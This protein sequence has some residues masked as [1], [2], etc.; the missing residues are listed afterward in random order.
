LQHRSRTTRLRLICGI[1]AGPLYLVVSYAEAFTRPGFDLTRSA[2]SF[3]SLGDLGWIQIANFLVCGLLFIVAATGI[4][5]VLRSQPS[6]TWGPLLIAVMGLAM[7]T[8]G[9][10]RTDPAFG[11]PPGTP[12]TKPQSL[13]WH[14]ALHAVSFTIA[15]VSWLTACLVFGRRFAAAKQRRWAAYSFATGLILLAPVETLAAPPGAV[16]I[17]IA[18]TIG[19]TWTSAICLKFLRESAG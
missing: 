18:A 9:V 10:F 1:A 2:F 4:R 13:T 5:Q 12:D 17:Y 16:L 19:W 14:A 3:L 7:M 8:G 6:G 15:I 11:Y